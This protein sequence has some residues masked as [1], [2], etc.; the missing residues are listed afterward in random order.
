M[1]ETGQKIIYPMHGAGYIEDIEGTDNGEYY[2]IRIPTGN[3]RIRIPM[4]GAE[5]SGIR[6][7][8]EKMA[9]EETIIQVG[10]SKP[11]ISNNWNQRYKEN[12]GRLKTGKLE[13]AA[14]V[15]KLLYE[16]EKKKKL[17]SVECRLLGMARQ[18]VLSEIISVYEIN[19]EKA[20]ELLAKWIQN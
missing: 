6:A 16:Q 12:F 7:P 9:V 10:K 19:S 20:E 5:K 15:I 1:F 18:I 8:G 13:E 14:K 2:I 11:A 4:D 3:V 17:S